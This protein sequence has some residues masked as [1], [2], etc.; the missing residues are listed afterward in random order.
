MNRGRLDGEAAK[1]T[2]ESGSLNSEGTRWMCVDIRGEVNDPV[3]EGRGLIS[4]VAGA[5]VD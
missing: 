3:D 5:H 2:M 1:V 4:H